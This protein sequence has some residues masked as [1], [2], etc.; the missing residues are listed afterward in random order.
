[1]P[2]YFG[3]PAA[4]PVDRQN[5]VAYTAT[6]GQTTFFA[7][8]S[9]GY[10][11]VYKNG[12]KLKTTDFT[13]TNGTSIVL[14]SSANASDYIEIIGIRASSP[15]DFYTKAQTNL[16]LNRFFLGVSGTGDAMTFSSSNPTLVSLVDGTELYIR[17]STT[18]TVTNPTLNL[19][20]LSLGTKTITAA[21]GN[22]LPAG[23]WPVGAD[24]VLR[25]N[26]TIDKLEL[27]EVG[28]TFATSAQV[29]AGTSPSLLLS[30]AGLKAAFTGAQTL[31]SSL[32]YQ[33]FPGGLVLQW[34]NVTTNTSS[35][36]VVTFP[37][38]FPTACRAVTATYANSF[39][40][41]PI[42]ASFG[43]VTA[44]SVAIAS[45]TTGGSRASSTVYWIAVGD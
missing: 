42:I 24:I 28:T 2:N 1:M 19:S 15:Y 7:V 17:P 10:V 31:G 34:G 26:A 45:Y 25:Y 11:D 20:S 13:A 39:G 30:P 33:K 27:L 22:P 16:L 44:T 9:P 4:Q 36:Q 43:N 37:I 29:L 5:R 21:G 14:T 23:S 38:S 6:S 40:S 32:G 3:V 18:N 41:A 12:A 35:D 8:Y